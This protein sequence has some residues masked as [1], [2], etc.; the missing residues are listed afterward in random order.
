MNEIQKKTGKKKQLLL[1]LFFGIIFGFLLQKGGATRYD[2]ILGQLL[3]T[4]FTVVK[5]MLSAVVTGMIGIYI[6]KGMGMV[7]LAPKPGSFGM[8]V[9]GGLLFGVGFALLGYCPGT[10]SGA[11]GDGHLDAAIGGVAGIIIGSGLFAALYPKL[12]RGILKKGDFGTL[13]F[14]ELLRVNGWFVVIPVIFIILFILYRLESS[15]L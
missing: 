3:L 10:I 5:I 9:I 8:S 15:G 11:V 2:V 6:L 12:S 4:D 14:P 1:G 13:T 7:T